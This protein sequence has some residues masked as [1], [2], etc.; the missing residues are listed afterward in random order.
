MHHNRVRQREVELSGNPMEILERLL[1]EK[2]EPGTRQHVCLKASRDFFES[3]WTY[4]EVEAIEAE[5]ARDFRFV[6][7]EVAKVWGPPEFIGHRNDSPYPDFYTAEE[8]CYWRKSD[9]LAM[10][11]WEHQDKELPVALTLAVLRPDEL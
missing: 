10:I 2:P 6:A 3:G 9:V 8:F 1:F 4:E 5:F 7:E 11:W